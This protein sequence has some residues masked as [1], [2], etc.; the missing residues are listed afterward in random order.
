MRNF[1]KGKAN[2]PL[3]FFLLGNLKLLVFIDFLNADVLSFLSQDETPTSWSISKEGWQ[4]VPGDL[5][6]PEKQ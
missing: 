3:H 5:G 6:G 4:C 1:F 2:G